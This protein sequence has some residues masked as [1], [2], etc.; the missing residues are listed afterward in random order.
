M[1]TPPILNLCDDPSI[2]AARG[3]V[4]TL[5][6]LNLHNNP[7]VDAAWRSLDPEMKDLN[8]CPDP[9]FAA[10]QRSFDPVM[11]DQILPN[12]ILPWLLRV[13]SLLFGGH[14]IL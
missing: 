12:V 7:T 9:N 1:P 5:P 4:P 14:W 13:P 2:A 3:A 6:I 8:S 10:A 11:D